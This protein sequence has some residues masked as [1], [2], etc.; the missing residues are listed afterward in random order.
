[1]ASQFRQFLPDL[2]SKRFE[3]INTRSALEHAKHLYD[4]VS[5]VREL[6][7]HWRALWKEPFQGVTSDGKYS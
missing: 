3:N 5:L 7:M 1:M 2:A 6:D 4:E